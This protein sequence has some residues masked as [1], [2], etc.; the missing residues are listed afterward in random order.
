MIR[1]RL[2][3]KLVTGVL[4]GAF[5]VVLSS[6]GAY[7]QIS[8]A[9]ANQEIRLSTVEDQQKQTGPALDKTEERINK[10]LD[11][12]QTDVREIRQDQKELLRELARHK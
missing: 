11:Q 9:Q 10:R 8:K 4:P 7:L 3:T 12:I 6:V 1:G 2:L 5:A